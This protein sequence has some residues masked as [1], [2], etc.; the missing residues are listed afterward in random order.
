MHISGILLNAIQQT[1]KKS[2]VPQ[3]GRSRISVVPPLFLLMIN[4]HSFL[5]NAQL[6]HNLLDFRSAAPVGNSILIWTEESF[7]PVTLPLWQKI[8]IYWHLHSLWLMSVPY[9]S[10]FGGSC[11]EFLF[12]FSSS[13]SSSGSSSSSSRVRSWYSFRIASTA[14]W[15]IQR[16]CSSK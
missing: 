7:Q 5:F 11:Q 8:N 13:W 9:C 12:S 15:W 4:R 14:F 10:H 2:S 1:H 3:K 16:N 6:R